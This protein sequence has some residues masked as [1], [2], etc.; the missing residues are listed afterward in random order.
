MLD[1]EIACNKFMM[2]YLILLTEDLADDD[3]WPE[4]IAET[5]TGNPAGWILG[6]LAVST[7]YALR[8]CG[9]RF[10]CSKDWH[11]TFARG[12]RSNVCPEFSVTVSELVETTVSGNEQIQKACSKLPAEMLEKE[13]NV[14]F[15]KD[16][17]LT[18]NRDV[19]VHLMTTHP[20]IHLGQL[21]TC[22]R[23]L[24]KGPAKSAVLNPQ[25]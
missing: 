4:S 23:T 2:E 25:S 1:S 7:D 20:A 6:H 10:Q 11:R 12:T 18:S 14:D 5:S 19:L 22:R 9:E 16:T 3:L 17:P 15:L 24:G 21:S 8:M 13:H